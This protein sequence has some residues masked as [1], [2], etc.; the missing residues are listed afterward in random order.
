TALESVADQFRALVRGLGTAQIAHGDLQHG[1]IIVNGAKLYLIDYDGL[2]V[3]GLP[4][5]ASNEIGHIN[6]QHPDRSTQHVGPMV[7][8]FSSIVIYLALKAVAR[9]P[10]L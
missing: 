7:D 3:P 4:V 2:Y 9:Q 1:N 8:R 10:N 5:S 6:Y